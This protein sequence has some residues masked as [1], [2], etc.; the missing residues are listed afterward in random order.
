MESSDQEYIARCLDS[1]PEAF[2]HLVTRYQ[3][4]LLSFLTGKLGNTERAEEATQETFVRA[5]FSL[6]KLRKC[7]SFF[8]WLLGIGSRVVKEEQ[9]EEIKRRS[10]PQD[11]SQDSPPSELSLDC[12]LE[13]A[14]A[15]LDAPYRHII[16]L[17]YYGGRRCEEVAQQ[18]NM[19]LGT[20]TKYLSRAYVMLRDSLARIEGSEVRK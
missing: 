20:V 6:G 11:I 13:K 15:E 16:L 7:E 1:H 18:L 5:Y 14:I 8:S 9:R 17:R 19:P 10:I 12:N 2:R 4:P 3:G